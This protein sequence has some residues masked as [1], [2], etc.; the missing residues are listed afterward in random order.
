[1]NDKEYVDKVCKKCENRFNDKDL[2]NI[3]KT[4]SGDYKCVN[5]KVRK[6]HKKENIAYLRK[7]TKEEYK[8]NK[9]L[10]DELSKI[11]R[12]G[13]SLSDYQLWINKKCSICVHTHYIIEIIEKDFEKEKDLQLP[14]NKN[15]VVY[16]IVKKEE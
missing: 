2:C 8:I 13:N 11:V 14:Y 1:M 5:E 12:S 15:E 16:V 6:S 7:I 4:M 9:Q 3:R 10:E